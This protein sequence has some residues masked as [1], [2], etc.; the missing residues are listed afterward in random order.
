MDGHIYI[1]KILIYV[2]RG[3][4]GSYNTH[5]KSGG[6]GGRREEE[7]F[8]LSPLPTPCSQST[9]FADYQTPDIMVVIAIAVVVVY[10]AIYFP[11]QPQLP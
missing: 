1:L 7:V 2:R 10:V 4:G 6:R 5:N 11:L 3:G 9:F 8:L